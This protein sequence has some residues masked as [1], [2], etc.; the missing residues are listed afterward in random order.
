MLIWALTISMPVTISVTVCSHL[1]AGVHLNKVVTA[2]GSHQE[3]HCA[4]VDITGLP[5]DLYRIRVDFPPQLLRAGVKAG[6]NSTT[7]WYGAGLR[8]SRS[9]KWTIVAVL[10][11]EDHFDVFGIFQVFSRKMSS[12]PR[13]CGTRFQQLEGVGQLLG[14]L[15]AACP[16]ATSGRSLQDHRIASTQ[17]FC[18]ASSEAR[19]R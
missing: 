12:L 17:A 13:L 4:G 2:V 14:V 7:F 3:F 16:A 5:G 6:V 15:P 8:Q 1:D 18:R 9:D 10:V 19:V 11:G